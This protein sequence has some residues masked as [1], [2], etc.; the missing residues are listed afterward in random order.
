ARAKH[1]TGTGKF[2][3]YLWS[4]GSVRQVQIAQS[5]GYAILD[6]AAVDALSKW[7]FHSLTLSRWTLTISFRPSK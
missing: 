7:R 3:V 4:D 6:K 2:T 1:L 5:T